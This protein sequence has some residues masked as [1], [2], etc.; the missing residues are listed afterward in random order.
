VF[1][2]LYGLL[3]MT[4]FLLLVNYIAALVAVQFLRGDLPNSQL[5]HFGNVYYSFLGVY[6]LC[7]SENWTTV[8]YGAATSEVPF[9]QTV[10]ALVYLSFWLLFSFCPS[11]SL[12]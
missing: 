12:R 3:N 5:M 1:G 9:G 8:L 6:Q 11:A 2:N 10:I 7:S 4:A